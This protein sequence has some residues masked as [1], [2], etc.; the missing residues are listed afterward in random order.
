MTE[1]KINIL[2]L[3]LTVLGSVFAGFILWA[4]KDLISTLRA[5][6][7]D[8]NALRTEITIFRTTFDLFKERTDLI[9]GLKDNVNLAHKRLNEIEK[10]KETSQ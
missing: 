3:I 4:F 8:I 1:I 9:P 10:G 5:F 2:P 7:N 6:K